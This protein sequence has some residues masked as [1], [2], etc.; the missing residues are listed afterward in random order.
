[1]NMNDI[2]KKVKEL[3]NARTRLEKDIG[4]YLLPEDDEDFAED[5]DTFVKL[6]EN[7]SEEAKEKLMKND[8]ILPKIKFLLLCSLRV[9]VGILETFVDSV[10]DTQ[11]TFDDNEGGNSCGLSMWDAEDIPNEKQLRAEI[12]NDIQT[13]REWVT[14]LINQL[15]TLQLMLSLFIALEEE[16]NETLFDKKELKKEEKDKIVETI[17]KIVTIKIEF[18]SLRNGDISEEKM[19]ETLYELTGINL[20]DIVVEQESDDNSDD[21]EVS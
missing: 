3:I 16:D 12:E 19:I 20:D 21:P 6:L 7:L 13:D 15:E 14:T 5:L 11:F 18:R 4:E 2:E 10:V 17:I 8:H 9:E 1:M